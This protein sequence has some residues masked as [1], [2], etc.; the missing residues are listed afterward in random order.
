MALGAAYG[1]GK[2]FTKISKD[3]VATIRQCSGRL[4]LNFF[5]MKRLILNVAFEEN[6][7]NMTEVGRHTWFGDVKIT[8]KAGRFD[9]ELEA[10]N[11][12]NRKVFSRVTY[13][14]MDIYRSTYRLRPFNVML[15]VR[16][17]IL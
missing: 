8:Y 14:N 13:T 17:N 11:I 10:N 7:T 5:P 3:A 6:Y 16:F 12:F 1:E 4:D 2:S 15:K 9:W